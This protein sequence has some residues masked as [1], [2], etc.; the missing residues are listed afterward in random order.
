M[1]VRFASEQDASALLAI[2]A[3][4]IDTSVTFET[5][6]PTVADFA[7]RIW[8]ITA[9][10]PYLLLEE[11]GRAIGYAYAHRARDRAAYDWYAELSVYLDPACTGRGLGKTLYGLLMDLL[12]MQGVRTAMGCVTLPNPASEALHASLGF[13]LAGV[14]Y[15]AGYKNGAW[16]DVGWFEKPLGSYDAPPAPLLPMRALDSAAVA[17]LLARA[18]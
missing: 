1:T 18:L 12:T 7:G 4:Y 13:R 10:Y 8:D 5:E 3:R 16:Q 2:Y 11:D 14:S 6:V 17:E 9:V 15:K